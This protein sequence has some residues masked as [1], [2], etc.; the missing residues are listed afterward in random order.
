V[1]PEGPITIL[2]SDISA[3]FRQWLDVSPKAALGFD[4]AALASALNGI[5]GNPLF[6][7]V[8]ATEY[9]VG[10]ADGL[11]YLVWNLL[12]GV[13][14]FSVYALLG[15]SA[16]AGFLAFPPVTQLEPTY[17]VW[18]AVLGVVGAVLAVF[19]GASMHLFGR[20]VPRLFGE[21]VILRALG[22][23]IVISLVGV[24]M[25]ELLFS[26]EDQIHAIIANPAQYGAALLL[27]MA[28]VKLLLL[29][30]SFKSGY[31]G[32]PTFPILFACTLTGLALGQIAPNVPIAILV[33]CIEAPALALALN[34][35][36]SGILLVAVIGLANPDTVALMVLSTVV[37]LLVGA[38]VKQVIDRRAVQ[39]APAEPAVAPA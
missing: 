33:L 21:R 10:A 34:A 8:F 38:A 6:T 16:F 7:G 26:G 25:P 39:T 17:F 3:W 23:G 24:L 30:L 5:I 20:L 4:V 11:R 2:V 37:G 13:I 18:A 32:G 35:P 15:L 22:A 31:L 12:A 14:G 36:L 29:G 9:E 19:T 1:G 27:L 28:V